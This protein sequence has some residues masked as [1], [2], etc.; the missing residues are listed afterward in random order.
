MLKETIEE[1]NALY[2]E[3][4]A[5]INTP[6]KSK[7][8]QVSVFFKENTEGILR[9]SMRS[10]GDID[11]AVIAQAFNGGGHK[12]AAGFKSKYPLDEIMVKVLKMLEDYFI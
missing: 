2:E 1:C 7:K 4:D 10:K 3:A 11:V 8:I 6:L 5:I 12:T 9:C